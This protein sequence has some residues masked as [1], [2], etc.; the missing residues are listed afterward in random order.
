MCMQVKD[1]QMLSLS[2]QEQGDQ[3]AVLS[4]CSD[5]FDTNLLRRVRSLPRENSTEK[6][7]EAWKWT[8]NGTNK[9]NPAIFFPTAGGYGFTMTESHLTER[10]EVYKSVSRRCG[11]ILPLGWQQF[12]LKTKFDWFDLL[13]ISCF[14]KIFFCF[15]E[16]LLYLAVN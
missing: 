3:P 10:C 4:R 7:L 14:N 1:S 9:T 2:Q 6:E 8:R 15:L 11:Y 5:D 12:W 13:K 16:K